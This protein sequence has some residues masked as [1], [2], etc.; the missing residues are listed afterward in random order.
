MFFFNEIKSAKTRFIRQIHV[1]FQGNQIREKPFH[2]SDP[3]SFFETQKQINQ[4]YYH[5]LKQS[6]ARFR[7]HFSSAIAGRQSSIFHR[8]FRRGTT[9]PA[10]WRN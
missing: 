7:G 3:C 2:Q 10:P 1:L 8:P 4:A 9:V 6:C 5:P